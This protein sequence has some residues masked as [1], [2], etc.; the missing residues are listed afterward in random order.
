MAIQTLSVASYVSSI[1]SSF[2]KKKKIKSLLDLSE[3]R[4]N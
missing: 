4:F 3:I 1:H 2:F